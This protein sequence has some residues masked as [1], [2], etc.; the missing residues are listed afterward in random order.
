MRL[1]NAALR[2]GVRPLS[3][4]AFS[5]ENWDRSQDELAALFDTMAD[6][7]ARGAEW[8]HELG[9]QV[10]WCGRCA[11]AGG[12]TASSRRSLPPW[13]WWRA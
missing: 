4:Y 8:L 13:R 12:A 7:I 9:V 11:G 6:G 1:V 10:R 2:L 5:T 3:I